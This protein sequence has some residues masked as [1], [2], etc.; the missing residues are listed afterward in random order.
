MFAAWRLEEKGIDSWLSQNFSTRSHAI[1]KSALIGLTDILSAPKE[2]IQRFFYRPKFRVI[3]PPTFTEPDKK[4]SDLIK[5]YLDNCTKALYK[6]SAQIFLHEQ[7]SHDSRTV[8]D[9]SACV[10]GRPSL[11]DDIFDAAKQ[12][13]KS[14]KSGREAMLPERISGSVKSLVARPLQGQLIEDFGSSASGT[15]FA[16][17][18]FQKWHK[19]TAPNSDKHS[20]ITNNV[21]AGLN[22]EGLKHFINTSGRR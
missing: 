18:E 17:P 11:R 13:E 7:H 22:P 8:D 10:Q 2:C 14:S 3:I 1:I 4:D 15:Y 19:A 5:N 9:L 12:V 16:F 20:S 21:E 6:T